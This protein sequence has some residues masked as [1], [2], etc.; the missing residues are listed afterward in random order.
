[1]T[2]SQVSTPDRPT[3]LAIVLTHNAPDA[4]AACLG[5]IGA[6]TRTV[7]ALLVVDNA[8]EVP[9]QQALADFEGGFAGEVRL[10]REPVNSGPA[11]GYARALNW[12]SG[13]SYDLAW[14][15]DDDALPQEDCLAELLE[16]ASHVDQPTFI[17][18]SWVQPDGT[19]TRY[20][21][22]CGVL[23]ARSIVS[24]VG[25]PRADYFWWAEDTEYLMWR[26]PQAGHPVRYCDSAV[27]Y[28]SKVRD[29]WG[30]PP[31]K[32]YYEARNTVHYDVWVRHKVKRL[33]R[34][35]LL[36]FAR[37]LLREPTGKPERL[38]MLLRGVLDG[39]LGRLGR[40]VVPETRLVTKDL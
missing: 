2:A 11:G 29:V 26:I 34:K 7:D 23:L 14:I 25:V 39:L 36:L 13:S 10:L 3:V 8:S 12:F 24:D 31:W 15:L 38:I 21:A 20:T 19:V 5:G 33:P 16:A 32:Y 6:Q 35:L 22:W 9:A 30:N 37:A 27:V 28:H 1:M 4:L 18:P 40:R 17:L